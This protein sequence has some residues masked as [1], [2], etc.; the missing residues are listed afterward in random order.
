MIGDMWY[1]YNAPSMGE[2]EPTPLLEK[3]TVIKETPKGVWLA[4]EWSP[5][6]PFKWVSKTSRKRFAYPTLE[7][8]QYSYR[9]RQAW[10]LKHARNALKY[11][12]WLNG[13]FTFDQKKFFLT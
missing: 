5:D 13:E 10:R 7:E 6:Y 3:F 11:A 4:T 12:D 8:A 9:V 2:G 1:R